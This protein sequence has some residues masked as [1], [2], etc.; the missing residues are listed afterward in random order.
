VLASKAKNFPCCCTQQLITLVARQI[1]DDGTTD[2]TFPSNP[3]G[4]CFFKAVWNAFDLPDKWRSK[5]GEG[6]I[7]GSAAGSLRTLVQLPEYDAR[8]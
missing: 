1:L 7:E 4:K 3:G 6:I 2:L 5:L 8:T